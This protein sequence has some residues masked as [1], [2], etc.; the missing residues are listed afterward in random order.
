MLHVGSRIP[1]TSGG[2]ATC[3]SGAWVRNEDWNP[4]PEVD[5]TDE[6][7]YG[8][9]LVYENGANRAQCELNF[10]TSGTYDWGDGTTGSFVSGTKIEHEYDYA[11]VSGDIYVDEFGRNYKQVMVDISGVDVTRFEMDFSF[12]IGIG[13][14]NFGDILCS[15]PNATEVHFCNSSWPTADMNMLERVRLLDCVSFN[16]SSHWYAA[17]NKL[18]V[19]EAPWEKCTGVNSMLRYGGSALLEVEDMNF[20]VI[21]SLQNL[22]FLGQV[23]KVGDVT[24]PLATSAHAAFSNSFTLV[25][26]GDITLPLATSLASMFYFCYSVESIG[27]I[28]APNATNLT[29][30]IHSCYCLKE[31]EM[32]D[33]SAVTVITG[34]N[35]CYSLNKIILP[36]LTVS[37]NCQNANMTAEGIDA[38]FTSLGTAAGA[39]TVTVTGNPGAATC[40]TS[41][42]TAKGWTIA[43]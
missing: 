29:N 15:W 26:V 14:P 31:F 7:F 13:V 3:V 11:T 8:L 18:A 27:I 25:S 22:F 5:K 38:L 42:A 4:M 41:I 16:W 35:S 1:I 24:A 2:G 10:T 21:T 19:L 39:Q 37:V 40:D 43:I 36:N 28:D 9:Y 20:S 12:T 33:C 32:T 23:R 34:L 17:A 6:Q 30:V